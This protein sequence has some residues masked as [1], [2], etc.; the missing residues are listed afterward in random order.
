MVMGAAGVTPVPILPRPMFEPNHMAPSGPG[1]IDVKIVFPP[2][3]VLNSVAEPS[4]AILMTR[5]PPSTP[6]TSSVYQMFP[7]G[8]GAMP[9]G[10]DD[11][12]V[13]GKAVPLPSIVM[14]TTRPPLPPSIPQK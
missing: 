13:P 11:E 14:R 6:A 7:S 2:S 5:A 9:D 10:T 12:D 4:G 3:P 1:A 8:P